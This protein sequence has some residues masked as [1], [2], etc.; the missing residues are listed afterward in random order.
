MQCVQKKGGR[1]RTTQSIEQG[2]LQNHRLFVLFNDFSLST[3]L[4]IARRAQ[5]KRDY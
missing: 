5:I 3:Y 4:L 2:M 1:R